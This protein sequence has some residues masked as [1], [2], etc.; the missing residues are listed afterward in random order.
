VQPDLGDD[1]LGGVAADAGDLIEAVDGGQHRGALAET[2]GRA[3][4]IGPPGSYPDRTST[5]RRRRA[6]E[7][8]DPHQ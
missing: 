8:E 6:C 4:C 7:R 2:G 1:R 5:G 3:G